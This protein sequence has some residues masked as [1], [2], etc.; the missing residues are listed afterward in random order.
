VGHA[1]AEAMLDAREGDGR[2]GPSPWVSNP[3]PGHWQP[4]LNAMGQPILDPTPWNAIPRASEDGNDATEP[5]PTWVALL[6]A[7]Y[8]EWVSGHNCLDA[9]HVAVLRMFFGD[10]P[11]GALSRSRALS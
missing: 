1:A 4:Q 11:V 3:A 7:P 9:A 5:D 8:P 2:F 6:T 10:D